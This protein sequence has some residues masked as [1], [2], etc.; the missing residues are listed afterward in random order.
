MQSQQRNPGRGVSEPPR[1][2]V[3]VDAPIEQLCKE[4]T[5][6]DRLLS[7]DTFHEAI[8]ELA[9]RLQA[10]TLV[11]SDRALIVAPVGRLAQDA[12]QVTAALRR[13][14][15]RTRVVGVVTPGVEHDSR[16]LTALG[17]EL[18]Q[19]DSFEES[20]GLPLTPPPRGVTA[21]R[22]E[23]EVET[24]EASDSVQ[25][26]SEQRVTAPSTCSPSA[27]P[28]SQSGAHSGKDQSGS[29]AEQEDEQH[30]PLSVTGMAD[31][32]LAALLVRDPDQ[33]PEACLQLLRQRLGIENLHLLGPDE[34][35]IAKCGEARICLDEP[36]GGRLGTLIVDAQHEHLAYTWSAWLAS[37]LRAAAH[38]E[39]TQRDAE[40][41]ALTGAGNRRF[42]MRYLTES[43]R[44]AREK[45]QSLSVMVFDVDDLKAY[46]DRFGH[47]AGDEV[48]R[49]AVRLLRS[50]I[51]PE[52]RVCRV[53][54]D[55]F[56]VVFYD[57]AGPRSPDSEH[58]RSAEELVRRF[59]AQVAQCRFPK[60]GE[61]APG[62]LSVSGGLATYPW[63]GVDAEE[64]IR[65]AD[66]RAMRA[67]R[68]GKN[69]II[70]G[71]GADTRRESSA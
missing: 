10:G 45:R 2:V 27:E 66:E 15:P 11:H 44:S 41:D 68:E 22:G 1:L 8:G 32:G 63:D 17:V 36:T 3:Y 39:R 46:N 56:V 71:R 62:T 23:A 61:E 30:A 18:V 19:A 9:T 69:A 51:R 34:K 67:K 14:H 40:T 25:R 60:L 24:Q 4:E 64:L 50:V 57:P 58:P 42:L 35:P 48:L 54:G 26:A 16:L 5:G 49:E 53:G 52:D 47:A 7:V 20:I 28:S 29:V 33:I 37:W 43:I 70:F 13:L 65:C 6:G 21:Q 55:E 12:Q 59:Q 31:E 38:V